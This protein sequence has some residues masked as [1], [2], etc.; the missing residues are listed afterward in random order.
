MDWQSIICNATERRV[1]EALDC[2]ACTWRTVSAIARHTCLSEQQVE[3]IIQKYEH[4]LTC[5]SE[6]PSLTGS[7]LV[8]LIANI[9]DSSRLQ[10]PTGFEQHVEAKLQ[11]VL[12]HLE[13]VAKTEIQNRINAIQGRSSALGSPTPKTLHP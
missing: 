6:T 3:E 10:A 7:R 12:T 11:E 2:P 4:D 1:F 13:D 5:K 9:N 8:G